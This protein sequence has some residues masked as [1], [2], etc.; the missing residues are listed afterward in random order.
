ML[1]CEN[2]ESDAGLMPDPM[3]PLAAAMNAAGKSA[4]ELARDINTSR[5]NVSRW[6]SGQVKLPRDQAVLISRVLTVPVKNLLLGDLEDGLGPAQSVRYVHIRGNIAAGVWIEHDDAAQMTDELPVV[7]GRWRSLEQCAY[8][9]HGP[10]MDLKR[11]YDGDYVIAVPYFD[12]RRE[13]THDDIVVVERKR[14][15][16]VERTCKQLVVSID[17]VHL[18]PRSSDPRFQA[19]V[20][21]DKFGEGTED[22]GT[23]VE[24]TGYVIWRGGP[25]GP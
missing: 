5:Q 13:P 3:T 24:I 14:G 18:W 11:I 4:S 10:S 23:S 17:G 9:V 7:G 12:A 20:A 2:N 19:P 15:G 21:V 1:L 16:L 22:D 8:R 6:A 25:I